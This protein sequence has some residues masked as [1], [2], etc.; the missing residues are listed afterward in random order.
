MLITPPLAPKSPHLGQLFHAECV[1]WSFVTLPWPE[2]GLSMA[3]SQ[4]GGQA[5]PAQV[6]QALATS[7]SCCFLPGAP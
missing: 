1:Q 7:L 4:A 3:D 6:S 2:R 5:V